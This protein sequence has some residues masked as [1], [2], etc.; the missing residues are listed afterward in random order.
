MV[1]GNRWPCN[2]LCDYWQLSSLSIAH[3]RIKVRSC[4][5]QTF[6]FGKIE[7]SCFPGWCFYVLV[8][9]HNSYGFTRILNW[10]GIPD[11][12]YHCI[13]WFLSGPHWQN[14]HNSTIEHWVSG[15]Q[16]TRNPTASK[17][18]RAGQECV[19]YHQKRKYHH[20]WENGEGSPPDA[21]LAQ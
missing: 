18:F 5:R 12:I 20:R 15:H 13:V 16:S 4:L 2:T 14:S 1:N 7:A 11:E 8:C 19:L 3:T 6:S 17:K 21:N 10:A 9:L